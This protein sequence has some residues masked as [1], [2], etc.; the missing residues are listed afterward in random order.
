MIFVRWP[1][2]PLRLPTDPIFALLSARAYKN[3]THCVLTIDTAELLERHGE[4]VRLS[5]INSGATLYRPVSRG[6]NTFL[7]PSGY[8]FDERQ[9]ARGNANAIAELT[10]EYSVPDV[11]ELTLSAKNMRHGE[12]IEVLFQC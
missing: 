11:E 12:V 7:P 3:R 10:V 8:P 4:S 5:A 1:V 2:L 9:R 6:S